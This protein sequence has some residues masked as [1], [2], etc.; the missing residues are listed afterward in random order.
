MFLTAGAAC[1]SENNLAVL[2]EVL[3]CSYQ[4]EE[5]RAVAQRL[6]SV[7]IERTIKYFSVQKKR[8]AKA[9]R[10]MISDETIY[11]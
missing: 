7:S 1:Q 11:I 4:S 2:A 10:L 9:E 3:N 6:P 8:P 5:T